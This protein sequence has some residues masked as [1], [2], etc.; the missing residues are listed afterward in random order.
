MKFDKLVRD[1]IP[2]IVQ[3]GQASED[4]RSLRHGFELPDG[5]LVAVHE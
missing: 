4:T 1:K 5:I 2:E 3:N